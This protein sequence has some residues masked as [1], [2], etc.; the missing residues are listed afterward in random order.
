MFARA[1]TLLRPSHRA[2][3]DEWGAANRTYPPT[4]G[5]PG[6][7]N[8]YLTNYLVPFGRKI[9][10]GR[11]SRV[12]A[13]TAAQSGKTETFLDVI[14]SRLDQK[15]AP[16]LYVGPSQDF[17]T[18]QFEP[19]LMGLLDEAPTLA[20]KVSRGKA[21]KKTQKWIAGVKVRLGYAGSSTSLKS[22]SFS[23]GLVDEYDEMMGNV[24]GQGDPL[25]LADARGE[26]YADF[27]IAVTST[28]SQGLVETE[29][30][31]VNGLEI[32]SMADP[33]QLS[34]PIW[35]L[36]QQGTRHHFAWPCPHCGDYFIPRHKNLRWPKGSTPTQAGRAAFV[37]CPNCG[38][39]IED[40]DKP[41]MV[42][43][44]LQIA[45]GQTIEDARA[46]IN[47]PD[48]G[49]WSCWTS[50]LCSPFVTFGQRA[51]K[52]L[53]A[54]ETGEPDK[55][56]TVMNANFGECYSLALN[57]ER[58]SW[59][60]VQGR[61]S[62]YP[63]GDVPAEA[64]RL[65]MGV[66]VQN[67]SLYW[68]IR[69][70]GARGTS[71]NVAHGQLFGPT[72]ED[73]IW[74]DLADLMLTPVGGLHIERVAVDSGYRPGKPEQVPEHKVYEFA[75]RYPWLVVPTKGK[76]VQNP[77]YKVSKIEVKSNGKKAGYSVNLVWL[78]TDFFKSLFMSRLATPIGVAG[79]F[80]PHSEADED[81]CRQVV[82]E[83]RVLE[84]CK[85]KWVQT[86]KQ[87][88]FLDCE[89]MAEAMG[90]S[91]NVQRI[92]EGVRRSSVG[93]D[94]EPEETPAAQPEGD[95][96]A[97]VVEPPAPVAPPSRGAGGPDLR[98]KFA[99]MGRG[100]NRKG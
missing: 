41:A 82:S 17:V 71:W 80:Y 53:T 36:W 48:N 50:G 95:P 58:Q 63:A 65:V 89:S 98:S 25:G 68:T 61:S 54:L 69:A 20:A 92:P 37:E 72:S 47:E 88:H 86:S 1:A 73:Q 43:A 77:P 55:I 33:D 10:E 51:E 74:E 96:E 97:D 93:H 67:F 90:Y 49:T 34:S 100:I 62:P 18:D 46:E 78:S 59:E 15:P 42:A 8:P 11:Y 2:T 32:W 30:D 14:G 7:R 56:Q 24:K 76:D 13:V 79:A 52:Y 28:P 23:L 22:D 40:H 39:A 38:G 75:R 5:W 57:A 70:F 21:S 26:T 81:Y 12:V 45:P 4:T 44:G 99:R 60:A 84:N 9:H 64:L 3:P 94:P 6:K 83:V 16:I 31:P 19:R 85:P 29:I 35:R 87:N 27:V 66:D 91:L